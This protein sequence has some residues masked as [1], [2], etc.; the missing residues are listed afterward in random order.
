MCG[1]F[2]QMLT[3]PELVRLYRVHDKAIPNLRANYNAAPTQEL[4]I[5]MPGLDGLT[6]KTARWGLVPVWAKDTKIGAQCI[7]ARIESAA[8]KPAFRSAWKSRRCVVPASGYF[9]WKTVEAPGQ[10][11]PLKQPY[12]V[13]RKDGL[14]WSFAGLWERWGADDLLTF[15][16]LTMDASPAIQ[17]LHDRQPV[18]LDDSAAAAWVEAGNIG[19]PNTLDANVQMWPVTPRMNSSRYEEADSVEPVGDPL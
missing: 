1:R 8:E 14:P 2:T 7:N 18:I 5:I 11:K 15:T 19:P 16:I 9:E 4:G 17:P 10:K 13:S 3:W 6:Y 12:Y